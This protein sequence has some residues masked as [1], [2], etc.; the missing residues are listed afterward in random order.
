M[1]L[2]AFALTDLLKPHSVALTVFLVSVAAVLGLGLGSL[3]FKGL[4]L[5]IGGVLFAGLGVGQF[6]KGDQLNPEV[7]EFAREFGLI[8]FVYTIGVQVGPGFLAS[9][10]RDGLPLNLMAAAVVLLGAGLTVLAC[11]AGGVDMRSAVGIFSGATTNTP[12][13]AAAQQAVR[14]T[15]GAA[16]TGGTVAGYAIAYPFG[17]IGI[18]LV[19]VV[20]RAAF[21]VSLTAEAGQLQ[22]RSDGERPPLA[23]MTLEVTNANLHGRAVRRVPS[24]D[25]G[26]V[27]ISRVMREGRLAV[28]TPKTVLRQGDV[29][30]AVGPREALDDL[31]VVVGRESPVDLRSV[32]SRITTRRVLVTRGDVL[33]KTLDE[34]DLAGRLGVTVTRIRRN[35][36]ELS[37]G[38][39]VRLNFGDTVLAVGEEAAIAKAAAIL[40]DST[41]SLNHPQI[42]PIFVGLALGVVLGSIPIRFPG[43]PAPVKLGLAGGP[44][45]AA[46]VLS[47]LGHFGPLVWHM[48]GSANFVLREVG[49][50]LFLACV[51]IKS[52][53]EFFQTLLHGPGLQWMAWGA[54]ITAV[55]LLVVGLFAR[56]VLRLN[57]MSLCGLL[58]GS[59]TDPP[60][61]AFAGTVTGSD[62]P[63]VSYA[64]VYPLVM[65]LRVVVAQG[66]V[67]AF[68]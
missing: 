19:M 14:D 41:K 67:L 30:L 32:P 10:R 9:L 60:A 49:I 17:V 28:A 29:L 21:R 13:L 12:S 4:H 43:M 54:L 42:I 27:V 26:D 5:G 47:R 20:F 22:A 35:E 11:K 64:A 33:G 58:A 68:V 55:P 16:G 3:R 66:L 51:G 2:T 62:A 8:L 53:G 34:L 25:D 31:R 18:I 57:Y 6:V 65:L 39:G 1:F 61:L 56:V 46:I 45:I 63:G 15:K 24:Y 59:M 40:G 50:V 23:T 7:M 38:P 44:L 48:P 36:V 52:G 37:P